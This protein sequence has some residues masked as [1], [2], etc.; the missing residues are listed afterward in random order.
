M[1]F[2]VFASLSRIGTGGAF[3]LVFSLVCVGLTHNPASVAVAQGV[4]GLNSDVPVALILDASRS[5]LGEVEGRRRMDVARDAM[6]QI[7]PGP[8]SQRR[9]SLLSFGNDR[10]NECETIPILH[11]YGSE[12]VRSTL[13]AIQALE[14]AEPQDGEESRFGSPLYR[15]LEV[16]MET[17]PSESEEA[18]SILVS[19]WAGKVAWNRREGWL[20]GIGLSWGERPAISVGASMRLQMETFSARLCST[21]RRFK[22]GL[23]QMSALL[24]RSQRPTG[25]SRA[26]SNGRR[27]SPLAS[28]G[29]ASFTTGSALTCVSGDDYGTHRLDHAE[30]HVLVS[31]LQAVGFECLVK[32]G[33][34][35][36]KVFVCNPQMRVRAL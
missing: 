24:L 31:L 18:V 33:A 4:T 15:A 25:A 35:F 26:S 1:V 30:E 16:A 9:A 27:Y 6:L 36:I 2:S 12:D 10:I 8:V 23:D 29:C 21:K 3:S 7:A 5:M 32:N 17:L 28:N 14:P 13:D 20:S 34:K 19:P 11:S 22:A